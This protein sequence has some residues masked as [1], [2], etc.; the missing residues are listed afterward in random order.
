MKMA[1]PRSQQHIKRGIWRANNKQWRRM[2]TA[3]GIKASGMK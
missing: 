3:K 2:A 1:T